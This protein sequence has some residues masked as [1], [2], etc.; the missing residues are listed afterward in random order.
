MLIS[1]INFADRDK[2]MAIAF[3][4][5]RFTSAYVSAIERL[6]HRD[7]YVACFATTPDDH[8]MWST[9]GG[10]HRGAALM[11]RPTENT[12]GAAALRIEMVTGAGGSVGKPITYSKSEAVRQIDPVRYSTEYP[13][14]DFFRSLGTIS[15]SQLNGFWYRGESGEMSACRAAVYGN[16][17]AWRSA[18]WKTFGESALYK[19]PEWKHEQE[20]RIVIHS[21]FD[22]STKDKRKLKY[23]FEDLAGIVFGAKADFEDKLKIMRIVDRKCAATGRT[24]FKFFQM[25]YLPTQSRFQLFEMGL[26]KCEYSAKSVP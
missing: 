7:W 15:D 9:Y 10:G 26:L 25:R 2:R 19:M 22:M 23:R 17:D 18:Y 21:G 13:V 3:L 8:S 5:N 16:E 11:F 14:I 20:Q 12:N 24:D 6:V 1:E 4:A